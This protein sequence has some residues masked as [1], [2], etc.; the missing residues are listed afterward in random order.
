[1]Q[2]S[3]DFFELCIL[4]QNLENDSGNKRDK[5]LMY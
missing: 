3:V 4:G 1:M 2:I 5:V